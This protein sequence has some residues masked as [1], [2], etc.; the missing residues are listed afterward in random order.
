[1][2][3]LK[4]FVDRVELFETNHADYESVLYPVILEVLQ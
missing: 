3:Y 4:I 1:M 2:M